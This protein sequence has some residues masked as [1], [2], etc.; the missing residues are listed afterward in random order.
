LTIKRGE[1]YLVNWNQGRGSEQ[2]GIRPAVVIQN[3]VGNEYGSTT[4]VATVTTKFKDIYP[5]QVFIGAKEAGLTHDSVID[6]GQIMTVDKTRL[7]RRLGKIKESDMPL[8]DEAIKI[9]LGVT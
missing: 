5:F 9:S 6:L 1:I 4:I 7:I 2:Q 3:N 8:L